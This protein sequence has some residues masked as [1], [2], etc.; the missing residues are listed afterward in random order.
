LGPVETEGHENTTTGDTG[1]HREPKE[2][3]EST[4][5]IPPPAKFANPG[6]PSITFV[7]PPPDK[8]FP[9]ILLRPGQFPVFCERE[10]TSAELLESNPHQKARSAGERDGVAESDSPE[11]EAIEIGHR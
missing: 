9:K 8:D 7:P 10:V 3:Q 2:P 11:E 5:A 4:E 6:L 1:K